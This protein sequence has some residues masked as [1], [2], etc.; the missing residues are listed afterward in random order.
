MGLLLLTLLNPVFHSWAYVVDNYIAGKLFKKINAGIFYGFLI[1]PIFI[2]FVA[3]LEKP[4]IPPV[5]LLLAF[6]IVGLAEVLYV[7]PYY[8]ALQNE[9]TAVVSSLFSIGKIFIPILAYFIIGETLKTTQ[10]VGFFTI[11]LSSVL[12]SLNGAK[13]KLRLNKSFFYMILASLIGTID[14]VMY[15]FILNDVSW[16]TGYIGTSLI[17]IVFCFTLLVIPAFRRDVAEDYPN[18][19]KSFKWIFLEDLLSII[20]S[21]IGTYALSMAPVTVIAGIVSIQPFFV[22]LNAVI[23]SKKSPDG[24]FR[25][26]TD[27]FSIIKKTILFAIMGIGLYLIMK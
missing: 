12:L 9:D 21:L 22:L 24:M 18:F 20:G 11:I 4:S 14:W 5:G 17:A 7:F 13:G 15:K 25:E 19:K 10:Y 6:L 8:K 3:L 16:T 27:A 1:A 23:F 26:K 2:P